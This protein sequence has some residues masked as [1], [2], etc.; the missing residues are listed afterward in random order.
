MKC[1]CAP[2]C[3]APASNEFRVRVDLSKKNRKTVE[4]TGAVIRSGSL[5]YE[6]DSAR[7]ISSGETIIEFKRQNAT[8]LADSVI[9]YERTG[10]S[11]F[12]LHP[13]LWQIDTAVVRKDSVT[14]V[15]DSIRL[16][17]LSIVAD[18]MESHRDTSN[19]FEAFGHVE[20]VRGT[21]ATRCGEGRRGG[22]L[23]RNESTRVSF[24]H[25]E[26][27]VDTHRCLKMSY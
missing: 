20:M 7:A 11:Y 26:V 19:R 24:T 15:A 21:L 2:S 9:H 27:D 4:D 1:A 8:I 23:R 3:V 14:G 5:V 13:R 12:P 16:D 17:T 10:I 18:R 25:G 6:R 22:S